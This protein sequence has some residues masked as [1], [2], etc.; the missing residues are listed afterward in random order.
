MA[1]E[2]EQKINDILNERVGINETLLSDQQD[3]ANVILDQVKGINFAKIEQSNLR[4]ITR[5][6]SKTAQSNYTISL[7][8]LGTKKLTNNLSEDRARIEKNI[9]NLEQ[10][11]VK[12]LTKEINFLLMEINLKK[13]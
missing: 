4:S 12:E 7:K 2:E 5:D 9:S 3:I 10:I 11:K 13:N 8:E 6:L 1:A